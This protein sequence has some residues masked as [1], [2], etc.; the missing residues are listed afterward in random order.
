MI[1]FKD[2][3]IKL[4]REEWGAVA[5]TVDGTQIVA[6]EL[7]TFYDSFAELTFAK[8]APLPGEL[9]QLLELGL[10]IGLPDEDVL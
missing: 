8:G 1:Y 9:Q 5:R 3:R 2:P 4:H 7:L 10:V 6:K